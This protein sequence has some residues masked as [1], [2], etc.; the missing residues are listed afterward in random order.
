M[1]A[2][3]RSSTEI[4]GGGEVVDVRKRGWLVRSAF[5]IF[6]TVLA[7]SAAAD[8]MAAGCPTEPDWSY[9]G[10]NG[11]SFWDLLFPIMCGQGFLQSPIAIDTSKGNVIQAKLPKLTFHYDVAH[12]IFLDHDDQLEIDHGQ[13]NFITIGTTEYDLI[14][15]HVHTPSEHTVNGKSFPMEIHLVHKSSDGLFAVVGVLVAKGKADDGVISTPSEADPVDVELDLNKLVPKKKD[16]VRFIGSLTT[17]G[18][19]TVLPRCEEGLLWTVMLTPITMSQDQINAFEDSED[20]C[21]GT[22]VTNRP[23]QPIGNRPILLSK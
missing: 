4:P 3:A 22:T 19:T 5:A 13:G 21:W 18:S 16:Y 17:P 8:A 10:D 1:F 11:P 23:T 6:L 20:A 12:V 7:I 14:N 15:V 2:P 9:T